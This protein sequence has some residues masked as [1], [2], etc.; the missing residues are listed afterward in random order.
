MGSLVR[1]SSMRNQS[2]HCPRNG[3]SVSRLSPIPASKPFI[4]D[5]AEGN[6]GG[7]SVFCRLGFA[8]ARIIPLSLPHPIFLD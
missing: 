5:V 4:H 3:K 1:L 6:I 8:A 7:N 2:Q